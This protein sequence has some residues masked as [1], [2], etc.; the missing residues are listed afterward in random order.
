MIVTTVV[1]SGDAEASHDLATFNLTLIAEDSLVPAVKLRIKTKIDDLDQALKTI[2]ETHQ[3]KIV[4]DSLR[5]QISIQPKF[6]WDDNGMRIPDGFQA[7]YS[8][9]FQTDSMDKM[10]LIYEELTSLHEV[11]VNS[12]FFALKNAER[13]NKKALKNAWKKVSERFLEECSI[14]NLDPLHYE[15]ASWEA[16]YA[17]SPRMMPG[18][19]KL[20][21]MD[22]PA[23]YNAMEFVENNPINI[24]PGSAKVTVNLSVSFK[25]KD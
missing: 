7:T 23:Q 15:V 16:V 8:L 20:A 14:L 17:D 12:P 10:N 24:V 4:K 13:L 21:V 19:R 25:K 9:S 3:V 11:S 2:L 22:M 6:N 18:I 1:A 5:T